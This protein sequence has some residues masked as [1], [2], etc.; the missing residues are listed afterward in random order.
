ML[1][2]RGPSLGVGAGRD[3]FPFSLVHSFG[4]VLGYN[5]SRTLY[6]ICPRA[7]RQFAGYHRHGRPDSMFTN[8]PD[9][10][11]SWSPRSREAWLDNFIYFRLLVSSS[12]PPSRTPFSGAS[13]PTLFE[14]EKKSYSH[15]EIPLSTDPRLTAVSF[16]SPPVESSF[17]STTTAKTRALALPQTPGG[18]SSKW[19][20][21]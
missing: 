13:N 6:G 2:R 8:P 4:Q 16:L 18:L 11:A 17:N 5:Y 19:P 20:R 10:G 1:G 3:H 14:E 7:A 21:R 15:D 9:L 12:V